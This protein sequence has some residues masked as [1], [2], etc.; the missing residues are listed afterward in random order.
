M[1]QEFQNI[2]TLFHDRL[3]ENYKF[4]ISMGVILLLTGLLSM[5]AP[6][7]AGLSL[8]LMV[9]FVLFVAGIGQLIFSIKTSKGF[10][11]TFFA[12]LTL[13]VGLYMVTNPGEALGTL[14][15]FLAA[16][17]IISGLFEILMSYELR[18]TNGWEWALF[19]GALSMLLGVMIW[20]QFPLSG[21]WAIG[22]LVGIRL[23]FS[24]WSLLMLGMAARSLQKI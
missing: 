24:G 8:A 13:F 4:I 14:T 5:G 10:F 19:S 16:Y 21:V 12:L 23:F 9:G 2:D 15:L 3:K 11:S 1:S 7:V 20:N 6:L 17:L 22:I 18:S